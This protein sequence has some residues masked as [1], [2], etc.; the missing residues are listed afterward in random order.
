MTTPMLKSISR[1][2]TCGDLK[3]PLSMF[4]WGIFGETGKICAKIITEWILM[5]EYGVEKEEAEK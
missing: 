5:G 3:G 2:T 4:L 1:R